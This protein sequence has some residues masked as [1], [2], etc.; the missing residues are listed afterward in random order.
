MNA[1]RIMARE[2]VG[3]CDLKDALE[4]DRGADATWPGATDFVVE[5][6]RRAHTWTT[7]GVTHHPHLIKVDVSR[8]IKAEAAGRGQFIAIPL[9]EPEQ[10]LEHQ[11]SAGENQ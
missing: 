8:Q 5:I 3:R 10:M 11:S 4:L 2:V 9:C 1:N 6:I 7:T